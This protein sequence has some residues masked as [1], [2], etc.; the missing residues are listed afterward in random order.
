MKKN[1]VKN[2]FLDELRK[3]PIIQVACEKTS[4]SRNSIYRWK[5]EDMEF[6]KA[7]DEALADGESFINEMCESQLL[8]LIK[9]KS[10]PA[11]AF[12]LRHRNSKFRD[13]VEVTTKIEK[14]E[15]LTP[16]QE[17]VVREALHLSSINIS[18][19]DNKENEQ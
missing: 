1:K 3:I 17:A 13:K 10:W 2:Q 14:D 7:V 16:E 4:L 18:N 15:S 11:L 6:S 12:W 5:K 9:D 19:I 8:G